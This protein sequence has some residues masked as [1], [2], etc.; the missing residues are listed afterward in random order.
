[1]LTLSQRVLGRIRGSWITASAIHLR[2]AGEWIEIPKSEVSAVKT[3]SLS[4]VIVRL[5][6]GRRFVLELR[7]TLWRSF[8]PVFRALHDALDDNGRDRGLWDG[9]DDATQ[10]HRGHSR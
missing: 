2:H 1:M 4:R 8:T 10:F 5:Y 7:P 3:M 9:S 6:D